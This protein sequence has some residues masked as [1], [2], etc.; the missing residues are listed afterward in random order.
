MALSL[1]DL[2]AKVDNGGVTPDGLLT[3]E[4]YNALL[5]AVKENAENSTDEHI[6]SVVVDN[7]LSAL[8]EN[9]NKP[10]NSKGIAKAIEEVERLIHETRNVLEPRELLYTE[11]GMLNSDGYPDK[12]RNYSFNQFFASIRNG[13]L[14]ETTA[15]ELAAEGLFGRLVFFDKNY[16][17]VREEMI[18][19]EINIKLDDDEKYVN[20][21][22]VNPLKTYTLS[23]DV[24][25]NNS[26]G[27]TTS[28]TTG[29]T[30]TDYIDIKYF[31]DTYVA[32]P[33]NDNVTLYIYLYDKDQKFLAIKFTKNTKGT[34][35][36]RINQSAHS[37][38]SAKYFRFRVIRNDSSLNHEDYSNTR[39]FT[40][41]NFKYMPKITVNLPVKAREVCMPRIADNT[42]VLSYE[43]SIHKGTH[44]EEWSESVDIPSRYFNQLLMRLPKGYSPDGNPLKCILFIDGTGT[45]G[46]FN[47]SEFTE[48]KIPFFDYWCEEGYAVLSVSTPTSKY[49]KDSLYTHIV[50]FA[51]PTQVSALKDAFYYVASRYNISDKGCFVSG[52]S[53]GGL[54]CAQLLYSK[55][56][57]LACAPMAPLLNGFPDNINSDN[58]ILDAEIFADEFGFDEGWRQFYDGSNTSVVEKEEYLRSQWRKVMGYI[59]LTNGAITSSEDD[60]WGIAKS[61]LETLSKSARYCSTPITIFMSSADTTTSYERSKAFIHSL[62]N[63]GS[64]ARLRTLPAPTDGVSDPH[65]I[66]DTAP[67]APVVDSIVTASGEVCENIPI[68]FVEAVQ[69]FREFDN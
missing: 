15:I 25:I 65:H 33:F 63:G 23:R 29:S 19:S 55:L 27:E 28:S 54:M 8:D 67:Q 2:T 37:V 22:L 5:A 13:R 42:I 50:N 3:A 26:T 53:Q 59:P 48:A 11:F 12:V 9:S 6:G 66:V 1:D 36:T 16:A 68:T 52:K 60:L 44:R 58:R 41:G 43:T 56:P 57:I 39:A 10:V 31:D 47:S 20:F 21:E 32:T 51:T 62:Q 4:E 64:I 34:S 45:N 69:F 38:G 30:V 17:K 35:L 61:N 24:S 14:I 40:V 49:A 7:T 46:S 18:D